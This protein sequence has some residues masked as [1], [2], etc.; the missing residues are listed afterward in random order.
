DADLTRTQAVMGTPAYMSPEQARGQT[1]FVGP[2]ADVWALGAI[3]YECLTGERPFDGGDGQGVPPSDPG[4]PRGRG[5]AGPRGLE[6]I[7]LKCLEK[8]PGRR[9]PSAKELADD[10]RRYLDHEPITA[11][12]SGPLERAVKWGRRHPT[13]VVTLLAATLGLLAAVAFAVL[14][15]KL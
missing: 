15:R 7:C 13:R 14:T 5:R 12:P 2:Q 11:R 8:E 9:Y 1:K 4:P 10:L 6:V 3:L